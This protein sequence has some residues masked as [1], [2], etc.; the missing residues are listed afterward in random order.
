MKHIQY[1]SNYF[2]LTHPQ[3]PHCTLDDIAVPFKNARA[4]DGRPTTLAI[5]TAKHA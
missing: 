2:R 1:S 5:Y 3:L 4:D